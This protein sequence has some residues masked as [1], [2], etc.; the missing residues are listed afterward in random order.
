M[1]RRASTGTATT[2]ARWLF[3]KAQM[4]THD[5]LLDLA[6]SSEPSI[7]SVIGPSKSGKTASLARIVR[8]L[9]NPRALGVRPSSH[10]GDLLQG[11][12]DLTNSE[13]I[14]RTGKY[15]G[16]LCIDDFPAFG[17]WSGFILELLQRRARGS[18]TILA[19]PNLDRSGTPPPAM[20][21]II[22]VSN[23]VQ[24]LDVQCKECGRSATFTSKRLEPL[25]WG[26]WSS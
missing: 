16:I 5:E 2:D 22:A 10:Q 12:A 20:S 9:G 17:K 19:G 8:L 18:T 4:S 26:C 14:E 25:C 3:Q 15:K 6:S 21:A 11:W 13:L 24:V 23:H 7:I 1:R